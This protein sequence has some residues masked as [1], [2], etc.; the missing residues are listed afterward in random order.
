MGYRGF[1]I[2]F[3]VSNYLM[4][5]KNIS[6]NILGSAASWLPFIVARFA[7]WRSASQV[8]PLFSSVPIIHE[9]A[10][11]RTCTGRRISSP[12]RRSSRRSC[13]HPTWPT[14]AS[15]PT[16]RSPFLSA[17]FS[18]KQTRALRSSWGRSIANIFSG[19]ATNFF[20]SH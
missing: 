3:L 2:K 14:R 20:I 16:P 13:T 1:I 15:T 9:S 12:R 11:S 18:R 8:G 4:F 7:V 5:T 19:R 10:A 17:P 6:N